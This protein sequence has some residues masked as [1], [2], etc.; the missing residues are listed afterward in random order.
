[1]GIDIKG[2]DKE[3]LE[4]LAGAVFKQQHK[5]KRK[6][7]DRRL[8][9]TKMLLQNYRRLKTHIEI[10]PGNEELTMNYETESGEII[11]FDELNKYHAKSRALIKY[12]DNILAAYKIECKQ[13]DDSDWRRYNVIDKLYLSTSKMS[14]SEIATIYDK[15]RST[16]DRDKRRGINDIS[17]MLYGMDALNDVLEKL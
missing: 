7:R 2:L 9:N 5:A 17:V 12:L 11:R 13:G 10:E 15:D 6:E 8:R 4:M 3:Q 1:M 14:L 16:I